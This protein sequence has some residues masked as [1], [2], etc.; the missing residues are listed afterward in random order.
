[1]DAD[2]AVWVEASFE[3]GDGLLFEMLFSFRGE[4]YVVV[5]GFGVIEFANG[6]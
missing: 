6:D 2:E 3:A 4:G 5:L 1:M